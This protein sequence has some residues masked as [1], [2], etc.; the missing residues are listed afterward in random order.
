MKILFNTCPALFWDHIGILY[1]EAIRYSKEGHE[2]YWVYNNCEL[3]ICTAN[4]THNSFSCETCHKWARKGLKLLPQ[5]VRLINI[6]DYWDNSK[7]FQ[8]DYAS[9]QEIKKITY[10]GVNVGY[11]VMASY[12]SMTRNLSPLINS[13]SKPYF[14]KL[15][16][17]SCRLTDALE[18]IIEEIKPDR[19]CFFNSR[20][21]EWRPPYDLARNRGIETIS[22]ER[23]NDVGQLNCKQYFVNATPHNILNLQKIS[24]EMWENAILSEEEKVEIGKSFFERRRN[25]LPAGDKVYTG[26]QLK[27]QL[28]VDWDSTKKNIVIFN[29]SEDEYASIGDE[30]DALS[31]FPTQYKGIRYIAELLEN[32]EDYHLY[33]R[34]HPNL[35]RI[36]YRYHTE[37]LKLSDE[38]K[39]ITVIAGK[40]TV[41]S[42]DLMDAA[43]KVVV[44]GSTI[45]MEAAY[46]GKPVILLA[47]A[48]YYYT[49]LCYIPKLKEEL[50]SL[51]Q[52]KLTP[53]G[54][55]DAIKW[56][57]Y[58]MYRNTDD[59]YQYVD[60]DYENRKIL[61]VE[62]RDI[63]YLKLFGSS[64]L[65]GIYTKLCH[66]IRKR[67]RK[68][69]VLS[70][71]YE[72]D[73]NAA[74]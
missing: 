49:D 25:S 1:D 50:I 63:H 74:L 39:N 54:N 58:V 52:K 6:K 23:T 26:G 38:Y 2:V 66:M 42:Y 69:V 30:Y 33:L 18:K 12:I 41:S 56:G 47:G 20:F 71:P 17:T 51:L 4:L 16:A 32:K 44:F 68:P 65:Y 48:A 34:I 3:D 21:F 55:Y 62:Y 67:I 29:S 64:K 46:W 37:L 10:K 35:S 60:F 22:Y 8:F 24:D 27:G 45:G 59:R 73:M 40:D 15:I 9:A 28:P 53:K 43:D 14:D 13:E 70:M 31:L 5:S 7:T 72:E 61:G 57:F 36:N 11:A 19:V